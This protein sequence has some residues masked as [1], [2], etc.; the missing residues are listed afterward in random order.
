MRLKIKA[1][2]IAAIVVIASS[3]G[4]AT[5]NYL[6]NKNANKTVSVTFERTGLPS[7]INWSI[8]MWKGYTLDKVTKSG[9][10]SPI[11]FN[12]LEKNTWYVFVPHYTGLYIANSE[13]E[14]TEYVPPYIPW[15]YP[16][17]PFQ[18]ETG[19]NSTV[20]KILFNPYVDITALGY[21]VL[22]N[23]TY[24]LSNYSG[25]E[26]SGDIYGQLVPGGIGNFTF[27]F[28]TGPKNSSNVTQISS[29]YNVITLYGSFNVTAISL[30][31]NVS[32]ITII[33]FNRTFPWHIEPV[34][35]GY[36][37]MEA[38]VHIPYAPTIAWIDFTLTIENWNP[39]AT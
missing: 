17:Q 18:F 32:G 6:K 33:G 28:S 26:G 37:L 13:A 16:S 5:Y 4:L 7:S 2:I 24:R 31:S 35:K 23:S 11:T 38:F 3:V 30:K 19:S 34:K 21:V 1:V 36:A 9:N 12:H 25:L 39:N 15:G 20:Q 10:S 29:G 8:T 14:G 27:I 22:N